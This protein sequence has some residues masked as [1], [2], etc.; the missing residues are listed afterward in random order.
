[1]PALRRISMILSRE[2]PLDGYAYSWS[3]VRCRRL[4]PLSSIRL[5]S[6]SRRINVSTVSGEEKR[7]AYWRGEI[8]LAS[9]VSTSTPCLLTSVSM[10]SVLLRMV[11]SL[12][13]VRPSLM[14]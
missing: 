4:Y 9:G 1:M 7:T 14:R 13:A 2:L 12:M 3:M 8:S 6:A 11:A 5:I 10:S